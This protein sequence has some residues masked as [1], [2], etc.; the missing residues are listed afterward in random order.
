MVYVIEIK[1]RDQDG[2]SALSLTKLLTVI[3]PDVSHLSWAIFS[4][5]T[6][7]DL[8]G[9]KSILSLERGIQEAP[10]G[11]EMS[12]KDLCSLAADLW[13]VVDGVFVGCQDKATIPDRSVE[14]P[15]ILCDIVV[16]MVDSSYWEI[17]SPNKQLMER[18]SK[19]FLDVVMYSQ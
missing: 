13:Q 17:C 2:A 1:D 3:E 11:L 19:R 4:L 7:G 10:K 6:T 14:D 12:W 16:E 18:F 8:K 5:W 9:G 15:C